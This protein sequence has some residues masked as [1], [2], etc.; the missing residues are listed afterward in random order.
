[1]NKEDLY[2]LKGGFSTPSVFKSGQSEALPMDE[3]RANQSTSALNLGRVSNMAGRLT[4]IGNQMQSQGLGMINQWGNRANQTYGDLSTL[5][6]REPS[7]YA[8]RAAVTSNEAFDESKGVQDRALSRMGIN[9]N[10][11]RFVGLQTKWGLARAAAES[12]ARTKAAQEAEA[13]KFSRLQ[14][15]FGAGTGE[16]GRGVGLLT[17]AA[18][19]FGNA[20]T[21]YGGLAGSYDKLAQEAATWA[22]QN[23]TPLSKRA[24]AAVASDSKAAPS[25]GSP[26]FPVSNPQ[27]RKEKNEPTDDSGSDSNTLMI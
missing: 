21:A 23:N 1:M 3:A 27:P 16:L 17:G 15:L 25:G 9:P 12:A 13:T 18:G 2:G 14:S 8:D 20:G 19:A 6:S 10:S 7:W 24:T 26:W 11:G 4:G 22:E 5:A